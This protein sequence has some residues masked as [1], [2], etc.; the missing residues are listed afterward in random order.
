M[1]AVCEMLLYAA[2]RAEHV[3]Q[4]IRPALEAGIHVVC[5][6]FV[7]SSIVYQGYGRQLGAQLV[8]QTNAPA[9]DGLVPDLTFLLLVDEATV[10]SRRN[11]TEKDRLELEHE[12][13]FARVRQGYQDLLKA[14][15]PRLVPIDANGTIEQVHERILAAFLERASL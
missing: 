10:Q 2:S 6:R 8:A 3:R 15:E 4:T 12:D 7:D 9:V 1:G 11:A 14:G 5:D 13:F